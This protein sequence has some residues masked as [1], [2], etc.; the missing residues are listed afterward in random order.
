[1][2]TRRMDIARIFLVTRG[3]GGAEA[4]LRDD[5]GEAENG[6][7]RR[8]QLVAHIGEERSLRRVC[9]FGF[10][11]LAESFVAGFFKFA[12]KIFDLEP[13]ARILVRRGV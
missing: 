2:R 12:C 4:F 8:A 1:M 7:E 11:P 9:R 13:Q 3:A 5:F 10:E 6:I